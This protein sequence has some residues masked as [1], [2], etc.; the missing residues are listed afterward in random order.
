MPDD[1]K[2]PLPSSIAPALTVTSTSAKTSPI[3]DAIRGEIR[4]LIDT[5][6]FDLKV[7][8]DVVE[9]ASSGRDLVAVRNPTARFDAKAQGL[10]GMGQGAPMTPNF[11]C[12][13]EEMYGDDGYGMPIGGRH[14]NGPGVRGAKERMEE[15]VRKVLRDSPLAK[16]AKIEI[17]ELTAANPFGAS[18]LLQIEQLASHTHRLLS[19]RLGI[20]AA[21]SKGGRG[22]RSM[23]MGPGYPNPMSPYSSP[24]TFG[25]KMG[26]EL[27]GALAPKTEA[28]DPE[29]LVLAIAQARSQGMH[30]VAAKLETRLTGSPPAPAPDPSSN[31]PHAPQPNALVEGGQ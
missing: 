5:D 27:V 8:A 13:D 11:M 15:D 19:A 10:G 6:V 26:R 3:A 21:S 20:S 25:A 2:Q 9:V 14:W 29:K 18:E 24:E 22:R 17:L 31:E 28:D 16:A 12:I 1:P 30:D 23:V 4:L 7:L